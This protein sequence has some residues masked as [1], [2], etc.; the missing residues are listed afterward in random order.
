[1]L[2]EDNWSNLTVL[3]PKGQDGSHSSQYLIHVPL[4]SSVPALIPQRALSACWTGGR[5]VPFFFVVGL[6]FYQWAAWL[7]G[8]SRGKDQIRVKTR[9]AAGQKREGEEGSNIITFGGIQPL[10]LITFLPQRRC[11]WFSV[12][13]FKSA[14]GGLKGKKTCLCLYSHLHLI[15]LISSHQQA[16]GFWLSDHWWDQ[17]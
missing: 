4:P 13:Y 9:E 11:V 2:Q 6:P 16:L 7:G 3:H 14:N 12:T 8:V 1:M 15:K 17:P 10:L 5:L